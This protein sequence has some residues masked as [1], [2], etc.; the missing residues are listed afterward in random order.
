MSFEFCFIDHLP[1]TIEILPQYIHF[2]MIISFI[3]NLDQATSSTLHKSWE[4][5]IFPFFLLILVIK[6][7]YLSFCQKTVNI[8]KALIFK[9]LNVMLFTFYIKHIEISI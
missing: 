5:V 4:F 7:H 1:F 6:Q 9:F 8:E 2:C 3:V